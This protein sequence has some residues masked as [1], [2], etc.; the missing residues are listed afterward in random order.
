M[1]DLAQPQWEGIHCGTI[2]SKTETWSTSRSNHAWVTMW[3]HA[4]EIQWSWISISSH[5]LTTCE[6]LRIGWRFFFFSVIPPGDRCYRHWGQAARWTHGAANVPWRASWRTP[7][8]EECR[9]TPPS[10]ASSGGEKSG[11]WP[12][13][14]S[15]FVPESHRKPASWQSW[16]SWS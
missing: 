2:L 15:M 12:G 14:V 11:S 7:L 13:K 10:C 1:F 8:A 4:S 16:Q 3:H 6:Y 9:E 5:K